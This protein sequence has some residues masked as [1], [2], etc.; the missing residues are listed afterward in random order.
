MSHD[1]HVLTTYCATHGVGLPLLVAVAVVGFAIG[2]CASKGLDSSRPLFLFLLA[3]SN[4][5]L[6]QAIVASV[7]SVQS[8]HTDVNTQQLVTIGLFALWSL[9][10]VGGLTVRHAI[11]IRRGRG[12]HPTVAVLA[13][14]TPPYTSTNASTD[15]PPTA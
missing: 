3:L 11:E 9:C 13:Q 5:S 7:E 2:A 15:H 6:F 10:G 12:A 4:F 8:H 1:L 14:V